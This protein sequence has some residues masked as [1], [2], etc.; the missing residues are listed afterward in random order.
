MHVSSV[1]QILTF[2][3]N[4]DS[5]NVLLRW[6]RR[7]QGQLYIIGYGYCSNC[8]YMIKTDLERCNICRL[9]FR[10]NVRKKNWGK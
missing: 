4:V 3:P 10:R 6:S 2:Y 7:I 1:D 5:R 8:G 9:R